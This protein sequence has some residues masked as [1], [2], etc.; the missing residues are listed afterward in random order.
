MRS[1]VPLLL[2][3]PALGLM[4]VQ[5]AAQK[6][7]SPT[8]FVCLDVDRH[9]LAVEPLPATSTIRSLRDLVA[10]R[11]ITHC[12]SWNDV[13]PPKKIAID[14]GPLAAV[15]ECDRTNR[16]VVRVAGPGTE[17]PRVGIAAAPVEM[18]RE[19]PRSLLPATTRDSPVF[20]LPRSGGPWRLQ[21]QVGD[22]ASTWR[23]VPD[24]EAA[25]TLTLRPAVDFR[26]LVTADGAPLK[27]SRFWLVR[28]RQGSPGDLLGFEASDHEGV[29]A[30]TLPTSEGSA[31]VVSHHARAAE[32][33][34]KL[35]NAPSVIELGPGLTVSGQTV[36]EGGEPLAAVRLSGMSF[37][38][39]SFGLMQMHMGRTG[40]DGRFSVGGFSPGQASLQ[41]EGGDLAFAMTFDLERSVNLGPVVLKAPETAWVRVVDSRDGVPVPGA[42]IQDPA[43]YW[44]SVGEDGLVRL[45]LDFGRGIIVRARGY[46][47][48]QFNLPVRAGV[49]K[50]EPLVIGLEPAFSI[51]GVFVAADGVTPAMDGRASALNQTSGGT[52][53]NV[54]IERDGS[55]SIDLPAGAYE[56]E[57]TA[58]NAGVR[59]IEV[60]GAAGESLDLG[61]VPAP[62]SAWIRGHVIGQD[63]YE[64]VADASLSY[65]RPS[66]FGPLLAPALGRVARVTTDDEGYFEMHGLELGTSTIRVQAEGFASRNL[67][68]EAPAIQGVDVGVV[69]LSHGRRVTVRSDIDKGMV[70]LDPGR[71]GLPRDRLD[72]KL[73]EGRAEFAAV[74]E[75]PFGILVHED[76]V[77]VCEKHED[78]AQGDQ[79]IVCNHSAA[80]VTGSV[81][82]GD[83]PGGGT[84]VWKRVNETQLPEGFLRHGSGPF[85]R[86]EDVAPTWSAEL[87]SPLDSH[88]RYLLEAVLPG[89]WEVIW[90]PLSGGIQDARSVTVPKAREAVLDFHYDGISIEGR[91]LHPDGQPVPLASVTAFPSRRTVG[92]NRNGRFEILGLEPGIH[93][94]R[95]QFQHLRSA[96][97]EA[98]LS[99][100]RNPEVV[101]LILEDDPPAT[102]LEIVFRGTD[103]GF[104]L[105]EMDSALQKIVRID[106]GV[107]RL[108]PEPPL[109]NRLRVA[110]LTDG[111]WIL[112]GWQDLQTALDRGM[113]FNALDSTSSI[114]LVG[115]AA[116]EE[117]QIIG[118]GGW[119]LG[120]LRLWFNGVSTFSAGET[121]PNLPAGEYTVRFR[122]RERTV[123]TERRRATRVVIEDL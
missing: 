78:E 51:E 83:Q 77:P 3:L 101:R 63:D 36:D 68:V 109:P 64:P 59:R 11:E 104:C 12:W 48:T 27:D 61:V 5:A 56:L 65:I 81:T 58:G 74:P 57:L 66:R 69:E 121:V 40:R 117:A 23:H 39:D 94:L 105:V 28:P 79:V 31:A 60:R 110:C 113:E 2:V 123:W 7:G 87:D 119:D 85:T 42:R 80:R 38:P 118:P 93:Q 120:R 10:D 115:E 75:E 1:P 116:P 91:V 45:S 97:V 71:T 22:H 62:S 41:A 95:A 73:I 76:G 90:A 32:P 70:M 92:T 96:L 72:G 20:S 46:I 25:V 107:A 84:L 49:T 122:N 37:V 114:A 17:P 18:W 103:S 26:F 102:E 43:G 82:R 98:D 19:V 29:V 35:G 86:T 30:L 50:E 9:A 4:T 21:A 8:R 55:F 99:D 15:T 34:Q 89:E 47:L 100:P 88:G 16:L 111:R 44:T 33:F 53:M 67:H 13:C 14:E 106:A 24:H 52:G 54:G 112:D 108:A 6:N